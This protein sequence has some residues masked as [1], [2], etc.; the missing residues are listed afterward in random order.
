MKRELTFLDVTNNTAGYRKLLPLFTFFALRGPPSFVRAARVSLES[1]A[2]VRPR[3]LEKECSKIRAGHGR[4]PRR[5]LRAISRFHR[6]NPISQLSVKDCVRQFVLNLFRFAA[7]LLLYAVV[8]GVQLGVPACD[9]EPP[10]RGLVNLRITEASYL[11][12]ILGA[13]LRCGLFDSPYAG[14]IRS[15]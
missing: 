3:P 6:R 1:G 13:I 10:A 2:A 14:L 8:L 11:P 5:N 15:S 7:N 12:G 9:T 4:A